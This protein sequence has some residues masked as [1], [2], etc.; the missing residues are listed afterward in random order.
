MRLDW[1][2]TMPDKA[3]AKIAVKVGIF[4]C[5]LLAFV[6][7]TL[8]ALIETSAWRDYGPSLHSVAL[9]NAFFYVLVGWGLK[10]DSRIAAVIGFVVTVYLYRDKFGHLP[11]AILPSLIILGLANAARA[12]FLFHKFKSIEKQSL[13]ESTNLG[14][15]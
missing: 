12:T 7:F 5:G 8:A 13:F 11:G 15:S 4:V 6:N 14:C 3:S 2:W 10:K 1:I 9:E